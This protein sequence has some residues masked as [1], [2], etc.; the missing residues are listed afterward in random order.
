MAEIITLRG[1]VG[2]QL[3]T[4]FHAYGHILEMGINPPVDEIQINVHQAPPGSTTDWVSE[5]FEVDV[6]CGIMPTNMIVKNWNPCPKGFQ[7]GLTYSEKILDKHLKL[8]YNNTHAVVDSVLHV[9]G[10]DNQFISEDEYCEIADYIKPILV[11]DDKELM[12]RIIKRTGVDMLNQNAIDDWHTT[13]DAQTV[14]GGL[15]TFILSGN[16]I[17]Y[18]RKVKILAKDKYT[19]PKNLSETSYSLFSECLKLLPNGSWI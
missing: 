19:G 2:T 13:L 12:K 15:S 11:G 1:G 4:L 7:L 5:L 9:R 8:R 16:L 10:S 17:K 6:P 14:Y 18:D 3:M